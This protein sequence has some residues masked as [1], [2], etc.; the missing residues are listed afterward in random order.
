[1][2][3]QWK[4]VRNILPHSNLTT[5]WIGFR[6]HKCMNFWANNLGYMQVSIRP[7]KYSWIMFIQKM[8]YVVICNYL[9]ASNLQSKKYPISQSFAKY[10]WHSVLWCRWKVID[11]QMYV[12]RINFCSSKTEKS[13]NHIRWA[14]RFYWQSISTNTVFSE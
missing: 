6:V 11:K 7:S 10:I 5:L 4:W 12:L 2:Y 13:F 3:V 1:M 14:K 8:T 9:Q